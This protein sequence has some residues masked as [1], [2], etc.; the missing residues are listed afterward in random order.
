MNEGIQGATSSDR[1]SDA[2]LIQRINEAGL[3]TLLDR[4][5]GLDARLMEGGRTMAPE[6][7]LALSVLAATVASPSVVLVSVPEQTVQTEVLSWLKTHSAT[8]IFARP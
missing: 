3:N 7:R 1:P 8:V 2:L 5:G 6:D 4:V